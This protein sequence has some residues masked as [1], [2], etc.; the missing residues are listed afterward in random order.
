M[1]TGCVAVTPG[2]GAGAEERLAVAWAGW[3]VEVAA[4][5]PAQPADQQ[6]Y[7]KDH[8]RNKQDRLFV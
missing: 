1:E 8:Q 6:T 5:R 7:Q 2:V 4:G 3:V